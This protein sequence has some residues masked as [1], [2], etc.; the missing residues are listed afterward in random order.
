MSL[1]LYKNILRRWRRTI[2]ESIGNDRYSKPALNGLDAKLARH[3]NTRNG[4]FIEAGAN[5]GYV[6]SNTYYLEKMR[7][8]TGLLV[9]P[10][11]DLYK[12]AK[13]NRARSIVCNYALVPFELEGTKIE[14]NYGNLMSFVTG[15][16]GG[17]DADAAHM[18]KAK[19]I[20]PAAGSYKITV[21]GVS[22][23][24][25]IDK[26]GIQKIDL[27]S[28]DVEGFE[29]SALRG[30]DFARHRPKWICVEARNRPD[31]DI[32]LLRNYCFVEQLT[33]MDVLYRMRE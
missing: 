3:I 17:A 1:K 25:L 19:R 21:N 30:L 11:P 24:S 31:I 29:V 20:D 10:I 16:L 7:G 27:L 5:D 28:L 8:W 9:E 4:V 23:S 14:L 2:F 13:R 12:E 26:Y 6:Q 15:A 22:L 32:L 18:Q 33:E